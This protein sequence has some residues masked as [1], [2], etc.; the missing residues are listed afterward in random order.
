MHLY[1]YSSQHL[2]LLPNRIKTQ[3]N[4][5]KF[6]RSFVA[7]EYTQ[8]QHCISEQHVLQITFYTLSAVLWWFLG[9]S[10][11]EVIAFR[12]HYKW[13]LCIAAW[14]NENDTH[15]H[16]NNKSFVTFVNLGFHQCYPK[17]GRMEMLR[18]WF[19]ELT[20]KVKLPDSTRICCAWRELN[21]WD[22]ICLCSLASVRSET[23][24]GVPFTIATAAINITSR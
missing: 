2:C 15:P 13:D 24:N 17:W 19:Q 10:K 14:T 5:S 16:M 6:Y 12:E 11:A 21:G 22:R 9:L 4:N 18:S 1:F 20:R 3:E 23:L 7:S 8:E